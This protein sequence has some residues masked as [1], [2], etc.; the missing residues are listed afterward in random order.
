MVLYIQHIHHTRSTLDFFSRYSKPLFFLDVPGTTIY[1]L[2]RRFGSVYPMR[3]ALQTNT[4]DS[5]RTIE[6]L[7]LKGLELYTVLP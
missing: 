4:H 5:I 3:H 7:R 2:Y 1:V 6:A